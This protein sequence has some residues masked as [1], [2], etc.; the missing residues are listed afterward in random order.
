MT[1]GNTFKI[2]IFQHIKVTS[3]QHFETGNNIES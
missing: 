2:G 3:C 1:L